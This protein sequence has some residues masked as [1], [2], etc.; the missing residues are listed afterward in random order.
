[1]LLLFHS[2]SPHFQLQRAF[3]F[4]AGF[5]VGK[6]GKPGLQ[7]LLLPLPP[8]SHRSDLQMSD[9]RSLEVLWLGIFA[10]IRPN[11]DVVATCVGDGHPT[12]SGES[13]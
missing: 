13:L 11:R 1:M 10:R 2:I 12:F 9:L 4:G 5:A 7:P 8:E 6:A 3:V